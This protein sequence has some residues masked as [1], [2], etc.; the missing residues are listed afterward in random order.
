MVD[1]TRPVKLAFKIA[2]IKGYVHVNCPRCET[3]I[4]MDQ[5]L[6]GT[7]PECAVDEV[8]KVAGLSTLKVSLYGRVIRTDTIL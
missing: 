7:V 8:I 2:S 5:V 6:A 1:P 4:T 3:P